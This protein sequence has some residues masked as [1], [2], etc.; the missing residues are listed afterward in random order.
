M[1]SLAGQQ[2]AVVLAF[3]QLFGPALE[4]APFSAE[5]LEQAVVQPREA[6]HQ[7]FLGK[8]V[9]ALL[10]P[11]A[12]QPQNEQEAQGWP[13]KLR[14]KLSRSWP[15]NFENDPLRDTDFFSITPQARVS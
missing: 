6:G 14:Q 1:A 13:D 12:Q 9:N 10:R 3:C 15:L 2:G 7:A 8:L 5:Q 11:G 4:I